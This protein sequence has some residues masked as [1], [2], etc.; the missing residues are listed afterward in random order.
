MSVDPPR[1][2]ARRGAKEDLCRL[3][4][5]VLELGNVISGETEQ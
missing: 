1:S 2:D 5:Y 4:N 3:Q